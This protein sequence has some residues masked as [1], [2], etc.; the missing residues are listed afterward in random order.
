MQESAI[1]IGDTSILCFS[2]FDFSPLYC[3]NDWKFSRFYEILQSYPSK[4][5]LENLK[6]IFPQQSD[7]PP[8]RK[9]K[10]EGL[11]YWI[12]PIVIDQIYDICITNPDGPYLTLDEG[13]FPNNPV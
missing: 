10:D 6:D 4:S 5:Y 8:Q 1:P 7:D 9:M 3:C 11:G 2:L 12:W 13:L